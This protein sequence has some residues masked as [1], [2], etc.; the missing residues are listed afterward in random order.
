MTEEDISPAK[1]NSLESFSAHPFVR[2]LL[3]LDP[4]GV[5]SALDVILSEHHQELAKKRFRTLVGEL[6]KG[7]KEFTPDVINSD[8]FLHAFF[9]VTEASLK[10]RRRQ[11]IKYFGRMLR[12][13]TAHNELHL[14]LTDELI[15]LLD[16]L[17]LRELKLLSIL[18]KY[19]SEPRDL[20]SD[21]PETDVVSKYWKDLVDTACRELKM[22]IS[23]L[24]AMLSKLQGMGLF[25]NFGT[26]FS[27]STE[28]RG[29]TTVVFQQMK[30]R[31]VMSPKD[32]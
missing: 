19:E 13:V 14:D 9:S 25:R 28:T 30:E 17:S 2:A 5:G 20:P 23:E 4:L 27:N 18:D 8:D 32:F 29:K 26:F 24:N 22:E 11:K 10:T 1:S 3:Q 15:G 12:S 31:I 16:N 7:V 21:L 6:D